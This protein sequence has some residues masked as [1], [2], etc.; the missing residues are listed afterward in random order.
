MNSEASL[1][2][3]QELQHQERGAALRKA[4]HGWSKDTMPDV[5]TAF[6]V[7]R[8]A[9]AIRRYPCF[10]LGFRISLPKTAD[11]LATGHGAGGV[12]ST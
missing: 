11:V 4:N 10:S 2:R 12:L 7:S 9:K 6:S 3:V 8:E 1:K 5:D